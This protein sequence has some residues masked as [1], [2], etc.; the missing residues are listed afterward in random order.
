MF[1]RLAILCID[2]VLYYLLMPELP[3]WA[4][5]M[6]NLLSLNYPIHRFAVV[7]FNAAAKWYIFPYCEEW[8]AQRNRGQ[9]AV[10]QS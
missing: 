4:F 2:L 6:L 3:V 5:L 7:I 1:E 10:Q 8:L 9:T